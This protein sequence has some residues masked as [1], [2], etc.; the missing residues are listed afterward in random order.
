MAEPALAFNQDLPTWPPQGEWT[1]EDYLRLPDD[2]Q[3]PSA[4]F[5]RVV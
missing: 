3:R 1:W 5:G 2:G 4:T